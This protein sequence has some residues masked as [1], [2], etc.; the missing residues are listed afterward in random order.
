[1]KAEEA[2]EATI[3]GK[4]NRLQLAKDQAIEQIKAE[5]AN[6]RDTV[7]CSI[8]GYHREAF[9]EWARSLGYTVEDTVVEMYFGM[10]RVY[11]NWGE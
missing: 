10:V 3:K 4:A 9:E 2:R 8:D 5:A 7:A 1:M 11:L 6:G